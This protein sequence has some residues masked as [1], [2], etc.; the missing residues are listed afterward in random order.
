MKKNGIFLSMLAVII[1]LAMAGSAYAQG[2]QPAMSG[3]YLP[4]ERVNAMMKMMMNMPPDTVQASIER[5]SKLF[6]DT[7]LGNNSTGLSCNSCHP[8]GGSIGGT[9]AMMWK[10]KTMHPGI[11][12]LKGAAGHFPAPRG[13]MKAVVTLK[14]MNNMCIMSFL[15]GMPLDENSR[16]A[17]DLVAY[18]TSFSKGKSISPGHPPIVP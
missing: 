16:E 4:K 3:P 9:A 11:A 18:V 1:A 8:N 12:T 10:G 7:S 2:H 6:N 14:G 17:T 15:K 5:G 13:P